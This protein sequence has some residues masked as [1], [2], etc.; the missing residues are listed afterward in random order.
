VRVSAN[1]SALPDAC[2]RTGADGATEYQVLPADREAATRIGSGRPAA[3]LLD[4]VVS[5]H[6]PCPPDLKRGDFASAW[7]GSVGELGL[8]VVWTQGAAE[9]TPL[10][11]CALD[12]AAPPTSPVCGTRE[13][14]G[15]DDADL[16]AFDPDAAFTVD[17]RASHRH[18]VTPYAAGSCRRG[19]G[20]MVTR[21]GGGPAPHGKC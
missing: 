20:D 7:A 2:G 8:P 17:R 11:T 14:C 15:R 6:S 13:G 12:G 21:P 4:C 3:G 5:D 18:P 10:W 1:L 9:V 19:A 16:V